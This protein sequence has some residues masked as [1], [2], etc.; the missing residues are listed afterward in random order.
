MEKI[1][2][3]RGSTASLREG[4]AKKGEDRPEMREIEDD[5]KNKEE[6]RA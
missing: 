1:S 2:A 3:E 5:R 6:G 4:E